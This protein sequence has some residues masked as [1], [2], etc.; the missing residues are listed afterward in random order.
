MTENRGGRPSLNIVTTA[1][2]LVG[3]YVVLLYAVEIVD[4]ATSEHLER[5]GV[6]PRSL[7]GLDGILFAPLLHDNWAH[8]IGNTV[9]LLALGFLLGLSGVRTW[10]QVTATV[11][12]V[13]GAGVWLI[14]SSGTNH[15]GASGIVFGWLTYLIVRGVF[16]RSLGQILVGLGV[17][18]I[19]GSV[20]WGVLPGRPGVSWEGHLFGAV[21]GAL[22]AWLLASRT[23]RRP[24]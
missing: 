8:L 1:G 13:G 7:D 2:L 21:G 23:P 12:L 17:L 16:N 24:A 14:G 19:Y 4:V 5:N 11:W 10:L 6:H 3:A 15:I 9:P 18:V 20:L 22:A